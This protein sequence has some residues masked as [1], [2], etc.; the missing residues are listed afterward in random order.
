MHTSNSSSAKWKVYRE[1]KDRPAVDVSWM[2]NE[3]PGREEVLEASF[4]TRQL[5]DPGWPF[6]G[7]QTGRLVDATC[8]LGEVLIRVETRP[9]VLRSVM[10][11][12]HLGVTAA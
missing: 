6:E 1:L 8:D 4:L 2:S 3:L 12:H 11:D 7:P 5:E 9:R 10:R